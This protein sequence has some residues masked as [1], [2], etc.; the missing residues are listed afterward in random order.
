MRL[1]NI[2]GFYPAA[3]SNYTPGRGKALRC[4]TVHHSAGWEQTLRYLWADP[5]R[6][7]SS[8]F[9]V[10]GTVR[11]Q[12]VDTDDTAWCNSSWPSNQESLSCEV[13]GD[14]RGYYDQATLD[15]LT[16]VMYQCL[17]QWPHL[18]LTY[19]KDVAD[20]NRSTICP[21][22]LKDKGYAL[23]C[24]NNAK[25]RIARENA[26]KPTPAPTPAPSKITYKKITPKRVE[27]VRTANLW[28]FDFNAW[29]NAKSI[30]TYQQGYVIDVVAEA[31]N[32]LGGKYYMTAYSYDEGRIRATNGF[33]VADCKD[34]A[35]PTPAPV[36][37][38]PKWVPMDQPR[39]MQAAG[40]IRIFD[41]GTGKIVGDPI[42]DDT[43]I[44]LVE[45]LTNTDGKVYLRSKWSRDN[46]KNWGVLANQVEEIP[47]VIPKPEP[48]PEKPIDT[49]PTKPG[50][51]DVETRL[52]TLERIVKAIVEFLKTKFGFGG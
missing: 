7:G 2:T 48:L 12:Y 16:E 40:D 37:P 14:W 47:A 20:A 17:K 28:N 18:V 30:Q 51:G 45:K 6:N 32:S 3:S 11:E 39:K 15:N 44:D 13:R 22:D 36:P 31:T 5:A 1:P 23:T 50:N 19:H 41:I 46:N 38:A 33:N 25:A 4:F 43:Q 8:H 34:Y 52:S 26:P 24:W 42:A 9:Y 21:C 35:A 29:A 49:D 27:L 10:S